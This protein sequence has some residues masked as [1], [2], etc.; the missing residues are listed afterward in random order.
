MAVALLLFTKTGLEHSGQEGLTDFTGS[1]VKMAALNGTRRLRACRAARFVA[2]G[3]IELA[4]YGSARRRGYPDSIRTRKP[5][6]IMTCPTA[7]KAMNSV[8]VVIKAE[9]GRCSLAEA[10]GSMRSSLKAL[11]TIRSCRQ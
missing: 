11:P 8:T 9:M 3:K 7:C 10:T 5:S 1:T 4:G 2:F 6:E